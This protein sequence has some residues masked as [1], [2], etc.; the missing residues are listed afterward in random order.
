MRTKAW[1][2]D[3]SAKVVTMKRI[4]SPHGASPVN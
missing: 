3:Y 2:V 4:G 1:L